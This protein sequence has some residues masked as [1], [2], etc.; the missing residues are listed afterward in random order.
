MRKLWGN[1]TGERMW[2]VLHGYDI[3]APASKRCM[4]GHRRV[5]PTDARTMSDA[6]EITRLL[7]TKAARR[8]RRENFYASGLWLWLSIKDGSW[9]GKRHLPVVNDDQAILSALAELWGEVRKTYPRGHT[10]F[11]VGVT[12]Y[13]LSCASERQLDLLNNDDQQRRRLE[14][15][16]MAID[17]LN[18][19]YA[20]TVVS[21]GECSITSLVATRAVRNA[22]RSPIAAA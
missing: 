9:M 13:D 14:S 18:T 4:F 6:M 7:L 8:M 21:L 1:V 3:P 5:L 22:G 10:I 2:Y 15:A 12:L 17:R 16:S 20:A 19:S 11:R